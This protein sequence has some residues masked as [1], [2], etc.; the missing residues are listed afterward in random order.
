M[1]NLVFIL[2]LIFFVISCSDKEI[3]SDESKTEFKAEVVLSKTFG[4]SLEEK[5]NSVV[6]T[7]DGGMLILGNSNSTNGDVNKTYNEIDIWLTKIDGTGNK[8]WSKTIGGS[9]NDYGSSIIATSDG[10]YAI[11]GY[12][13]SKDGDV[14]GNVG[15]H[16]FFISKINPNGEKIWSKNYGFA[17]H[18][19][20]HKIIQTKDGGFFVAGFAEYEGIQGSGG[21][22]N[23]GTGHQIGHKGASVLHGSGEFLGVKLDANGEFQ[24]FR[25][26]G[27]TQNDVITDVIQDFDG[28]YI[29]VGYSES[30]NFDII[31][32]KGSYD[33]WVVKIHE[34]GTL[35]WK[36]NYGGSGID[37]AFGIVKTDNNS[38]LIVGKSNS[39]DKDVSTAFGGFDAWVIHIDHHGH[40]IWQKSFGGLEFD[41]A[42]SI[43]KLSNGNYGIIGNSRSNFNNQENKGQNDYWMFEID[44]KA[45]SSIYWQKTFGGTKIDTAT[46]FFQNSNNEIVIVGESQSNNQD[47]PNNK[48][49]NDL[50]LIKLK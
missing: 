18:D 14:P 7:N 42:T 37:Q 24:W 33:F 43:K 39:T 17:G 9:L 32:N 4:G 34:N 19:H 3:I 20:A 16:D 11:A 13:A 29:M 1:K 36:H 21:D 30:T 45:N 35:D 49:F 6:Q 8:V 22:Q 12:S 50:W 15:L 28:S 23:N 44:N 38:Y 40:L 2:L 47:V 48:G 46:D 31:D 27:G 10:N 25:Y 41:T 5:I 26:Y